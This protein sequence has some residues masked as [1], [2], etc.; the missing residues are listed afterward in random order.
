MG[1]TE[2]TVTPVDKAAALTGTAATVGPSA[3]GST[4]TAGNLMV[5]VKCPAVG[6]AWL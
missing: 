2:L 4:S 6:T 5:D 1:S 3:L